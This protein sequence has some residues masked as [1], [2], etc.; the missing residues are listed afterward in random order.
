MAKVTHS[1]SSSISEYLPWHIA[2]LTSGGVPGALPVGKVFAIVTNS[3]ITGGTSQS[4]TAASAAQVAKLQKGQKLYI[5][6]STGP[7]YESFIVA[8]V[9]GTTVVATAVFANSYPSGSFVGSNCGT[10]VGGL[11]V[12]K[13]G[14]STCVLTL[15]N[16]N[17]NLAGAPNLPV[18]Y[19]LAI[20]APANPSIGGNYLYYCA[21]DYGLF[22]TLT[23]ATAPDCT[24]MY[25]DESYPQA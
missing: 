12:N 8:S 19:G 22:Y 14:D 11:V 20:G 7:V 5:Y 3:V 24:I 10:N 2:A 9:S 25:L 4:F 1:R 23:G 18:D 15:Y 13:A 21:C 17:P 16:G 6:N